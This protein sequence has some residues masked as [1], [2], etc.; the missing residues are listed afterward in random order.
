MPLQLTALDHIQLAMPP[1]GEE[2]ARRFY[3]DLLGL[4]EVP[5]PAPLVPR[6]GVWFESPTATSGTL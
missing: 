6:G 1:A 2:D 3:G 4:R 5:K